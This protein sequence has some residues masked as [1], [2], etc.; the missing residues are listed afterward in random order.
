[1]KRNKKYR[2]SKQ[3]SKNSF[4]RIN[5]A[6]ERRQAY[7]DQCKEYDVRIRGK[8]SPRMLPNNWDDIP[9]KLCDCKSWKYITKRKNQFKNE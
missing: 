7:S 1:M 3:K 9:W 2:Y 6:S 4:R 5:F 8:R